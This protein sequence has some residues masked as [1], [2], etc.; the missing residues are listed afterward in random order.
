MGNKG[1]KIGLFGAA[2]IACGIAISK[3]LKYKSFVNALNIGVEPKLRGLEQYKL[4]IDAT[5]KLDNPKS[6]SLEIQ[7]PTIRI[8]TEDDRLITKSEPVDEM[9]TVKK[10]GVTE[11]DYN[12][13]VGVLSPVITNLLSNAGTTLT[14]IIA[15]FASGEPVKLGTNIKVKVFLKVKNIEK[16]IE[17]PVTL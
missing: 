15:Q 6:L 13:K 1:L 5:V 9:I 10:T 14:S 7:K 12:F 3:S 16:E 11:V 8:Y 2:S 17:I 4:N